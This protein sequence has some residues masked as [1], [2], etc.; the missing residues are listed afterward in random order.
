MKARVRVNP[1]MVRVD[2]VV[3]CLDHGGVH[4]AT[5]NPF[6]SDDDRCRP[7]EHRAV[8]WRARVGDDPS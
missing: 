6:D 7:A 5:C 1:K 4:D 2:G 3:Y 8:Y